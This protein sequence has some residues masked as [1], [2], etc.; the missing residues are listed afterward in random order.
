MP[1]RLLAGSG[2]HARLLEEPPQRNPLAGVEDE[3]FGA[4]HG[5][6]DPGLVQA[7]HGCAVAGGRQLAETVKRDQGS[8][9]GVSGQ[10]N[11]GRANALR[12]S[13]PRLPVATAASASLAIG[14]PASGSSQSTA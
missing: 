11:G 2:G 7:P 6:R 4:E 9:H 12:T 5:R 10:P 3:R 1:C 8:V 13:L 14:W